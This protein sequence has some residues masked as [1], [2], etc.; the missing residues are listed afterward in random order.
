[1]ESTGLRLV[2]GS[3][4]TMPIRLPR[5]LRIASGASVRMSPPS[6]MM[7]PAKAREGGLS[8]RRMMD[9]AVTLLPQP[10]SPTSPTVSPAPTAKLASSTTRRSP[11]S[12]SKATLRPSTAS[13]A[14]AGVQPLSDIPGP[15]PACLLE[16]DAREIERHHPV[17]HVD[18][19]ADPE[20]AG[21]AAQHIDLHRRKLVTEGQQIDHAGYR[22]ARPLHQIGTDPGGDVIALGI[23][24][25]VFRPAH[26]VARKPDLGLLHQLELRC[27]VHRAFDGRAAD[28]AFPLG[29]LGIALGDEV[30][31]HLHR[32][33]TCRTL[34]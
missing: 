19:L 27:H 10:D 33:V 12:V 28:F 30:A 25:V 3:W 31:I 22:I 1:M 15:A 11:C 6:K 21:D 8:S 32:P 29:V 24:A 13:S 17:R 20:I 34:H 26:P 18:D 16:D 14:G 2:I 7:R 23:G 5:R 9:M 4:K